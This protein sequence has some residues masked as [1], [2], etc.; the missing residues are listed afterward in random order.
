MAHR[1]YDISDLQPFI[2]K[3]CL[4]L[5]PNARLARRVKMEWDRSHS[6]AGAKVWEP[7][8]VYPMERWLLQQWQAAVRGGELPP[9]LPLSKVQE[10]QLWQQIILG[11][12]DDDAGLIN[13]A[14]AAELASEARELL[15]RWEISLRSGSFERR[16]CVIGVRSRNRT[17]ASA[18]ATTAPYSPA[19][20][21]PAANSA[22]CRS[23]PSPT[24]SCAPP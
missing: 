2:Q 7:L 24:A 20:R 17:S 6:E 14:G 19:S 11:Q 8:P 4:L 16:F 15:L 18:P 3:G 5:T 21:R 9:V 12:A 1:L 22:T 10:L 13:P 23:R